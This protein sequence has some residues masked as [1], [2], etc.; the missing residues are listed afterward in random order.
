MPSSKLCIHPRWPQANF[1][2]FLFV[3]RGNWGPSF[4]QPSKDEWGTGSNQDHIFEGDKLNSPKNQLYFVS[5]R[6]FLIIIFK[7]PSPTVDATEST[8]TCITTSKESSQ[9]E[10]TR[11]QNA[12]TSSLGLKIWSG[13]KNSS[14]SYIIT[15]PWSEDSFGGLVSSDPSEVARLY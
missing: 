3:R 7:S 5:F 12:R 8:L 9:S 4:R 1:S 13:S 10:E 2:L 11:M 15:V 14:T 6:Y